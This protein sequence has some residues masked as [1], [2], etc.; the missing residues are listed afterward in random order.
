MIIRLVLICLIYALIFGL[1]NYICEKL[2]MNTSKGAVLALT[3][4]MCVTLI[5]LEWVVNGSLVGTETNSYNVT[6][7]KIEPVDRKNL[8]IAV[9]GD[10]ETAFTT[11]KISYYSEFDAGDN[12]ILYITETE[13]S[14]GYVVK[15]YDIA[16]YIT[17]TASLEGKFVVVEE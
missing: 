5:S 15:G 8:I 10:V 3:M 14:D 17:D 12:V 16:H 13:Y 7:T 6:I 11:T 9:E 1:I 4:C 2:E